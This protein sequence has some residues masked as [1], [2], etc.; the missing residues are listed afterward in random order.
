MAAGA[1]VVKGEFAVPRCAARIAAVLPIIVAL[2]CWPGGPAR[3][4]SAAEYLIN[5]PSSDFVILSKDGRQTLGHARYAVSNGPDGPVLRG[6]K[7]F[8]DGTY[9]I[10]SDRFEIR[11]GA[12]LPVLDSFD[13]WFFAADGARLFGGHANFRTGVASCTEPG[14][15]KPSTITA[16]LKF[17]A[18]TWAG[19]SVAIPIE[20][21][22]REGG[23]RSMKIQ[24]FIC[25][26]R[27]GIVTLEVTANRRPGSWAD[28]DAPVIAVRM[29]P[30]L[31]WWDVIIAPFLPKLNAWFDPRRDFRLVGAEVAQYYRGPEILMV[32]APSAAPAAA[33]PQ[34]STTTPPSP[35]Q[36]P[37]N[38]R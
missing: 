25:V 27:P 36:P 32:A 23:E 12:P 30:K 3:A 9:D 6:E 5:F 19:S 4:K 34:R 14:H 38:A 17:P 2:M 31:G 37:R 7:R 21:L 10:E 11:P 24:V 18:D 13:H 15:G 20:H 33:E 35:E 8:L 22:L 28:Y 29:R 26:P 16:T 1:E